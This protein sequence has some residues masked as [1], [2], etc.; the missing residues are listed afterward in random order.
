MS[1][2]DSFIDEVTEEVRRDR[3]FALMRK[4]GWIGVL[5]VVVIVGGAAWNEWQKSRAQAAAQAFGDA[6]LAAVQAEDPAA[7]LTTVATDGER[8]A[9]LALLSAGAASDAGDRDAARAQLAAIAADATLPESY[10]QLAQL[11]AVILSGDSMPAADRD[12]ILTT[13]AAP[14][15]P[16]RA[17]ALEQQALVLVAAGDAAGAIAA[18]TAL[19][20]E[21]EITAGLQGRVRQLIVALGGEIDA[22]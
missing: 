13:L 16:F 2:T 6:V 19:L 5:L 7:A 14:G 22:G 3:L 18:L 21:P 1:D 12:A 20:Q 15:A 11:K 9:V 8:R 17:L 4:Y 10:R